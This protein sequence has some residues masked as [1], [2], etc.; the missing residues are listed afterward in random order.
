MSNTKFLFALIIVEIVIYIS[1][2]PILVHDSGG[3]Y[4]LSQII[5]SERFWVEWNFHRQPLFPFLLRCSFFLFGESANSIKLIPFI[6]GTI[7][8][9]YIYKLSYFYIE[10]RKIR[11]ALLLF[12]ILH[13]YTIIFQNSILLESGIFAFLSAI[14]FYSIQF[15]KTNKAIA[16]IKIGIFGALG[17]YLKSPV[18]YFTIFTLFL[19]AVVILLKRT[20][21]LRPVSLIFVS[22]LL[23]ILII[24]P[25]KFHPRIQTKEAIAGKI[26]IL[27][28]LIAQGV[29]GENY[30]NKIGI[31]KE[32]EIVA[33]EYK[34]L[35][36]FL[37]DGYLSIP[38]FYDLLAAQ[39]RFYTKNPDIVMVDFITIILDNFKKYLIGVRNNILLFSHL[40]PGV[41]G[42][43]LNL[44]VFLLEDLSRV[45][46][47]EPDPEWIR[48]T[49][50]R[51]QIA[52]KEGSFL[53]TLF[54]FEVYLF[55]FLIPLIFFHFFFRFFFTLFRKQILE[56]FFYLLTF[57]WILFFL[58]PLSGQERYVVPLTGFFSLTLFISIESIYKFS[59]KVIQ[60]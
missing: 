52:I 30:L 22:I 10:N 17:Y 53:K 2:P 4:Q 8:V 45:D 49:V 16:L 44:H 12:L 37:S 55:R 40:S 20:R 19:L 35:G 27:Q 39:Q 23:L 31:E 13:P 25:W 46:V 33:E 15:L 32:Y 24:S 50:E 58:L 21:R 48:E 43:T 7:G 51:F 47:Y 59:K 38:G 54:I 9:T 36:T 41:G 5:F 26:D 42:A 11:Y 3:Y 6:F 57:V 14:A 18:L 1:F 28:G 56:V 34:N 60:L 29:V